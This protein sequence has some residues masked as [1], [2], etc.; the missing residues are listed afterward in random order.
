MTGLFVVVISLIAFILYRL[1]TERKTSEKLQ[2]GTYFKVSIHIC[3]HVFLCAE[4]KLHVLF[5]AE[6][7]LISPTVLLSLGD[8]SL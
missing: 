6:H 5:C 1:K 3:L 7:V 2:S 8:K 4:C